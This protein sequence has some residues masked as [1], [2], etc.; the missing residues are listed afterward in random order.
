MIKNIF[1]LLLVILASTTFG[2]DWPM[3]GRNPQ[4]SG[5]SRVDFVSSDLHLLWTFDLG[6]HVWRYTKGTSVWSSSPVAAHIG[7]KTFVY[8]GAYDHNLYA[9]DGGTGEQVW[10][11]T[12]GGTLNFAPAFSWV[13]D[14]PMV[15]IAS[16]DRTVY[17]LHAV[18]GEKIWN[19]E[20]LPWSFTVS[21]ARTSSPIIA[22]IGGRPLVFFGIWNSDRKPIKGFQ[23]GELYA[24]NA[25]DGKEVWRKTVSVM[26]VSSPAFD[27][28]D[29]VPMVF[30]PSADGNIYAFDALIGEEVWR[31]TTGAEIYGSP[32]VAQVRGKHLVFIGTRFGNVYAL[33]A[34]NGAI[35]WAY[36]TDHA[37]DSTP[38]VAQ[39]GHRTILFVG[40]YDRCLHAINADTGE[41]M[42]RYE[43]GK[44]IS[45]SP[46]L[47]YVGEKT[48]A[49]IGSLDNKIYCLDG[50][51]GRLLWSYETGARLWD[52][53]TRGWTLWSSPIATEVHER[54]ILL[55]PSYDGKLY[56]FSVP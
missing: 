29:G 2:S 38:A 48:A 50:E 22:E 23:R 34:K 30:I 31:F 18:T 7:D 56:A 17:A 28:V 33:E 40:S 13:K 39:S 41:P 44:Y 21:E 1:R 5:W 12:T 49:F 43:T 8:I 35:H 54:T 46:A 27:E 4:H 24:L 20:T 52:Y 26:N 15:F 25:S 47:A 6:E 14:T 16:S 19:F 10:R 3:F 53:E 32:T 45:S 51:T 36:K 42:W 55:F 37:V 11:F 9:L